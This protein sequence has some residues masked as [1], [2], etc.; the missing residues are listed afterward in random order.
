MLSICQ[1]M[2]FTNPKG[3][4]RKIIMTYQ[5]EMRCGGLRMD[6]NGWIWRQQPCHFKVCGYKAPSLT[7]HEGQM[8]QREGRME[9]CCIAISE[10][11]CLLKKRAQEN[12]VLNVCW[13]NVKPASLNYRT[14]DRHV[15]FSWTLFLHVNKQ[16]SSI[17]YQ[18]QQ[19]KDV[20]VC[21]CVGVY[22]AVLCLWIQH[23][24]AM[25]QFQI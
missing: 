5:P 16:I 6:V 8:K 21:V 22:S 9:M 13:Q 1:W 25:L 23:L 20:C 14:G 24:E 15:L 17:H 11:V 10:W 18:S 3:F 19:L 4:G 2:G 7:Q 12:W